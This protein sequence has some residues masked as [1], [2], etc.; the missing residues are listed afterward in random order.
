[1]NGRLNGKTALIT[2]STSGI[3]KATAI[4]FA[5]EGAR[6]VV[7]GRNQPKGDAVVEAIRATGGRA[8]FVAADLGGGVEAARCLAAE[9]TQVLGGRVDVLVNNAGIFP[10]GPS[11]STTEATFD[12]VLDLNVKSI[13]FLTT[14][15]APGMIERGGGSVINMGSIVALRGMNGIALYS[16]SKAALHS[17]TKTWAAEFGPGGIRFNTLAPGLVRTEGTAGSHD[18]VEQLALNS[19]ARR[20][21]MP[22]EVASAAVYLASD[23]SAYVHGAE[24]V[25]DGGHIV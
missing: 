12:A 6:V 2:G 25:I 3:G 21:G 23:E 20:S 5:T 18:R 4:A 16:L 1:M 11:L 8:D 15:V 17:L 10:G 7:S 22:E 24:I 14:A 19:P 13:W 9:A